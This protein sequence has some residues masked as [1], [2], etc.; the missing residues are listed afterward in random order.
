MPD[1][2]NPLTY[3]SGGDALADDARAMRRSVGTWT[4]LCAV[5]AVGLAVWAGYLALIAFVIFHVLL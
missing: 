2:A 5:W 1:D 4:T 3:R